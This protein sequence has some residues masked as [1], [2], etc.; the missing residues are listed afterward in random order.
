MKYAGDELAV[1]HSVTPGL[2][3]NCEKHAIKIENHLLGERWSVRRL[4]TGG[5]L[6]IN[7]DESDTS[8]DSDFEDY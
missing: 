7:L 8:A 6:L 2:W 4:A 5:T 3:E 1:L